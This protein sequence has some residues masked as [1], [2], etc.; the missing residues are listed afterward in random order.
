MNGKN[1]LKRNV[2]MNAVTNGVDVTMDYEMNSVGRSGIW[3]TVKQVFHFREGATEIPVTVDCDWHNVGSP[4]TT[5]PMLRVSF[6]VEPQKEPLKATYDVPFGFLERP[7]DGKE[8]PAM[9]WG[10]IGD[11]AILN[12]CKYGYS[13]KGSTLNM[14]LIRSS[15]DP[16]PEP[17]PGQHEWHYVIHPKRDRETWADVTR[18]GYN[19]NQPMVCASVPFDAKGTSPHD[20]S[21]VNFD[22]PD[23]IPFGLKLAEGSN[24]PIARMYNCSEDGSRMIVT[25]AF[26]GKTMREVNFLEDALKPFVP[27]LSTFEIKSIRWSK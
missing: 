13:A 18:A 17:N 2:A 12:D 3:T 21:A 23:G 19:L 1:V 4:Q 11:L 5:N 16:D 14:T 20:W 26:P 27:T 10:A 25:S 15:Y 6:D 24:D 8:Y 22:T 7:V 9:K